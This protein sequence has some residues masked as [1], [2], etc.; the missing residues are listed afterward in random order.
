MLSPPL[1]P[2]SRKAIL[3]FQI[4]AEEKCNCCFIFLLILWVGM[5]GF[6]VDSAPLWFNDL[7]EELVQMH[8]SCC[9]SLIVSPGKMRGVVLCLMT[10]Q[11][12]VHC[13]AFLKNS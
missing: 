9:H 13:L 7:K 4:P 3:D 12:N 11:K 10:I 6:Y 2:A 1:V 8:S 5:F